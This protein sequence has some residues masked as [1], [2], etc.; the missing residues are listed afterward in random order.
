MGRKII[1]TSPFDKDLGSCSHKIGSYSII[2][3]LLDGHPNAPEVLY[4]K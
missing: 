4:K 1:L 3:K 2:K